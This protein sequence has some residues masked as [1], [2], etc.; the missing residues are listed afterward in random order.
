MLRKFLGDESG[1]TMVEYA[2]MASLIAGVCI[3][4]VVTVGQQTNNLFDTLHFG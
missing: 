4:I 3:A 1:A 2:I